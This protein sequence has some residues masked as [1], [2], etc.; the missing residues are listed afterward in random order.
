MEEGEIDPKIFRQEMLWSPFDMDICDEDLKQDNDSDSIW[1]Q[2]IERKWKEMLRKNR[3]DE[4]SDTSMEI[5][6]LEI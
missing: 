4:H 1:K 3:L 5:V 6:D 2:E